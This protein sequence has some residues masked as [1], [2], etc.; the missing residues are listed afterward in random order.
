MR[1]TPSMRRVKIKPYSAAYF[2]LVEL[3]P[4]IRELLAVGEKIVLAGRLVAVEVTDSG[5]ETLTDREL[6]SIRSN[7]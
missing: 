3:L 2:K 1:A 4:E 6:E 5:T 7:W